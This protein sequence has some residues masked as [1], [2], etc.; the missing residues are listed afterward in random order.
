M[1]GS[2]R[3]FA[4]SWLVVMLG[5]AAAWS[6]AG[7]PVDGILATVDKEVILR[8]DIMMEL[9]PYLQDLRAKVASDSD[10]NEQAQAQ[11]RE[12]LDQAI[13]NKILLREALLA[14]MKIT[15]EQVESRINDI[16]KHYKNEDF[17]KLLTESGDTMSDFREHIRKQVLAISM[18]MTKR[19][20]LEQ[21]AVVSESD[22]A[23]YYE[24]HKSEF[25]HPERIRVRRLFVA[26]EQNTA[27]R[28]KARARIDSLLD[29]LNAGADFAELAKAHSEGPEAQD[30]G[31]VG[32]IKRGDL[33]ETLESA[34]FAAEPGKYTSALETEFGFQVLKVEEKEES[35]SSTLEQART[36]IEPALR[37]QY[38][39]EK[40]KAWM[41][42]LRKRSR[43]RVFL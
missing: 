23:Q 1:K 9:G 25:T 41:A 32:W 17:T 13:E 2:T 22:V 12:T 43:V 29:E 8:S 28:A 34:A 4:G 3:R 19:Q 14:G 20:Q 27:E 21:E 30:G 7:E 40:Y 24:D 33:V 39:D 37:K 36:Q 38:A 15:D 10:F 11:I 35:G 16:R 26:A 42:E 6:V 5:L 18:G 31:M